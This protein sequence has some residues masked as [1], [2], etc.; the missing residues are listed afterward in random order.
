VMLTNDAPAALKASLAG[1]S[2][3]TGIAPRTAKVELQIGATNIRTEVAL[4]G[5]PVGIPSSRDWS[6]RYKLKQMEAQFAKWALLQH[7]GSTSRYTDNWLDVLRAA[8]E[9]ISY[10]TDYTGKA[11]SEAITYCLAQVKTLDLIHFRFNL[12]SPGPDAPNPFVHVPF[13]MLYD[14]N[15]AN[16][17]RSLAP[18]ARRVYLTSESR[19][20]TALPNTKPLTGHVLFVKSDAHGGYE[21][22]GPGGARMFGRLR[23]LNAEFDAVANS[24]ADARRAPP[25]PLALTVGGN[26]L[27]QLQKRLDAAPSDKTPA[28]QI[29]H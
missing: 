25:E 5:K 18:V 22:S 15:K 16:F 2:P 10:E 14:T 20:A 23:A 3:D 1:A 17:V 21:F 9:D 4:D 7:D 13:E 26:A 6:G 19:T 28:L 8:G 24:R 12:L 29:I 27:T 11:L